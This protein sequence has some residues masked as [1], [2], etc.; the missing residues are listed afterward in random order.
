MLQDILAEGD[1]AAS[2]DYQLVH[3]CNAEVHYLRSDCR[4][5]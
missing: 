5:V 4:R 2:G 3:Q 1:M